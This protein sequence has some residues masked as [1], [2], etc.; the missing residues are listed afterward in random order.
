MSKV[1]MTALR[2]T[3]KMMATVME[4]VTVVM[5]QRVKERKRSPRRARARRLREQTTR[6]MTSRS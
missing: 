1:S 3:K 5:S 2:K 6:T 4:M